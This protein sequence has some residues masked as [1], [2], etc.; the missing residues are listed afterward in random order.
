MRIETRVLAPSQSTPAN[1]QQCLHAIDAAACAGADVLVLPPFVNYPPP[2]T[3]DEVFSVATRVPGPFVEEIQERVRIRR[4]WVVFGVLERGDLRPDVLDARLVIAPTGHLA[5]L[6]R[7]PITIHA[8]GTWDSDQATV[9]R[10]EHDGWEFVVG[11]QIPALDMPTSAEG[12][13]T[14]VFVYR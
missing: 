14:R 2:W 6:R 9:E 7:R 4:I 12:S 13:G 5:G 8:D 11:G 1:L 10:I 3:A